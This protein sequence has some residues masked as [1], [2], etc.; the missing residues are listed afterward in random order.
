MVEYHSYF[1]Q[2]PVATASVW[3]ESL[4]RIFL[5]LCF[6]YAEGI[7]K[8]D[9]MVADIEELEK[10]DASEIHARRL[11]AKE[12]W[13]L[14]IGTH[15]EGE[16]WNPLDYILLPAA[17]LELVNQYFVLRREG[18]R[19]QLI[20]HRRTRDHWPLMIRATPKLL[21]GGVNM[22]PQDAFSWDFESGLGPS[23]PDHAQR[24]H[25]LKDAGK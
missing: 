24:L 13:A 8:G 7:W 14:H 4:T 18:R 3:P 15:W 20:P 23:L 10:M 1:C 22:V 25:F 6:L 11:N 12:V 19:L 2:R 5:R 21:Y 16:K 17:R 9:I